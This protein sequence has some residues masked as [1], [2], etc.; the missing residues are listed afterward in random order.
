MENVLSGMERVNAYELHIKSTFFRTNMKMK[1]TE[2]PTKQDDTYSR[3][4]TRKKNGTQKVWV[5]RYCMVI[6]K[7]D[8]RYPA[9]GWFPSNI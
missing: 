7:V 4:H 3:T 6:V 9:L 2:W 1:Q 8:C 5:F